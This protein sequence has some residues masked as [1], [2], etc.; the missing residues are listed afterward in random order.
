V[1]SQGLRH[2]LAKRYGGL[3]T[4]DWDPLRRPMQLL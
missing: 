1:F 3:V 2:R 4:M